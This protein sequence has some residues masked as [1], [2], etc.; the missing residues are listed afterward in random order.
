[1]HLFEIGD[2]RWAARDTPSA[3]A[4]GF[5]VQVDDADT[6]YF[7]AHAFHIVRSLGEHLGDHASREDALAAIVRH[8]A[9]TSHVAR[10]EPSPSRI[11][12]HRGHRH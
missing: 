2:G 12:E 8:A 1:M 11:V 4:R 5:V 7:T 10:S 6:P 3:A 9:R